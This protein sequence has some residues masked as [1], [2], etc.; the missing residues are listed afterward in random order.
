[1]L[2]LHLGCVVGLECCHFTVD[3]Y[4]AGML[5]LHCDC[6]VALGCYFNPKCV[7]ALKGHCTVE[8]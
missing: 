3:V 6:E 5:S 4:G 2:S 8:V 7:V 1:M